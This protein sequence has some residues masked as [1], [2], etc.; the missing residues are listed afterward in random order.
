LT[1][2]GKRATILALPTGGE[3]ESVTSDTSLTEDRAGFTTISVVDATGK[4]LWSDTR[5]RGSLFAGFR[6]AARE[7]IK[8]LKGAWKSRINNKSKG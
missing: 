3:H 4:V 2:P 7:V 6:S 8:E 1:R 5:R